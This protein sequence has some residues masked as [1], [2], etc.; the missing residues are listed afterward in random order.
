[1]RAGDMMSTAV[2]TIVFAL[3]ATACA[4][5]GSG[6]DLPNDSGSGTTDAK[7]ID[8]PNNPGNDAPVLPSDAAVDSPILP[9]DAPL[10]DAPP[11]TGLFCTD[12]AQC[13]TAGECCFDFLGQSP[14][15]VCAQGS[16]FLGECF[17]N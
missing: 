13:T 16:V 10:G 2:R 9:A 8:A 5:G 12:H 1:M 4:Q 7:P 15:G 3:V 17:P 6:T 11:G 14:Q